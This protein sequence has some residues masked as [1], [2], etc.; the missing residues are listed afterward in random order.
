MEDRKKR[1][2]KMLC[3]NI[4]DIDN[5]IESLLHEKNELELEIDRLRKSDDLPSEAQTSIFDF[6]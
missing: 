5:K 3:R 1:Y 4:R 6:I 2:I